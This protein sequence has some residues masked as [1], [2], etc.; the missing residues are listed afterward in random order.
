MRR[1]SYSVL[2]L[3]IALVLCS[4]PSDV[5]CAQGGAIVGIVVDTA[6]PSRAR[7]AGAELRLTRTDSF[8]TPVPG[9]DALTVMRIDSTGL[10]A[11]R[12]LRA[13]VY[14]VDVRAIGYEPYEGFLVLGPDGVA[15]PRISMTRLVP[16]LE[17]VVTTA[18]ATFRA[19]LLETSG[20]R[21]RERVGFGHFVDSRE[22]ARLQPI[23][24]LSLLRP[25]LH[26]CMIIYM[27]GAP[28]AI[29]TGLTVDE[30]LG[31]EVYTRHGNTPLEFQNPTADCGS[32]VL[33]TA[34]PSAALDTA[35]TRP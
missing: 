2:M 8:G 10:F 25:Y 31:V 29:P 9:D 30:L 12:G 34:I 23:S 21:T 13:G 32:I 7:L 17:R 27:N 19:R 24:V 26:G 5:A 18:S 6:G 35:G 15:H 16:Q 14:R 11:A 22:I 3:V 28:A 1:V 20:F 33:W 4:A